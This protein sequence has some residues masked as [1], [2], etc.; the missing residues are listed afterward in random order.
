MG[1]AHFTCSSWAHDRLGGIGISARPVLN[2]EWLA[3]ALR[4]PLSHQAPDEVG[5]G[6]RRIADDY[7]TG[8]IR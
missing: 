7:S 4:K 8:R 3:E 2:N 6:A 1:L 5:C